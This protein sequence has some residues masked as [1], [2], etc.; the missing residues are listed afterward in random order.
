MRVPA[1]QLRLGPIL[2]GPASFAPCSVQARWHAWRARP[3]SPLPR[4]DTGASTSNRPI[5]WGPN[6]PFPGRAGRPARV[7]APGDGTAYASCQGLAGHP[8][9]LFSPHLLRSGRGARSR[10][11]VRGRARLARCGDVH[12][13]PGPLRVAVSNVTALRPHCH[14]VF[15]W[16]ADV[17]L[18]GE[19]RLTAT[20]QSVMAR[21]AREA[22]WQSF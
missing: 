15:A 2:P 1:P 8:P 11:S 9:P 12:P 14:T 22:G 6:L 3:P 7:L 10:C 21:L 17:V 19:T 20:G 13:H 4:S 16:E 18:L 5:V